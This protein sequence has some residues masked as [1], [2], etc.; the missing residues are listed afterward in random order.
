MRASQPNW[1]IVVVLLVIIVAGAGVYVFF[2]HRALTIPS[3]ST[4]GNVQRLTVQGSEILDPSGNPIILRGFNWGD[5][6]IAQQQDAADNVS[7]GANVVRI[8]FSWYYDSSGTTGCGTGQDT[9][10]PNSP[11]TGYINPSDLAILDQE[12]TWAT[13][14]H[15]WT[16]IV[17][18]GEDCDFWTN[19]KIIPEFIAMWTFVAQHYKN[20]PYIGAYELI[21]EPSPAKLPNKDPNNPEVKALYEKTIAAIR[22]IDP[23]T[24]IIVGAAQTY[25]IRDLPAI[26]MSDQSN[27]IYTADFFEPYSY[28]L[29][30]KGTSPGTASYPGYFPDTSGANKKTYTCVYP[31]QGTTVLLNK[32]FLAGLL[33]CA[34]SFR[35]TYNVPVWINQVGIRTATP[36]SSQYIQDTL[37]L[38]RSDNLGF[39]WWTYRVQYKSSGMRTGDFGSG[40]LGVYY[41]NSD[42]SWHLQS[43]LLNLLKTFITGGTTEGK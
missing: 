31:G 5:W 33:S 13:S 11:Q 40:D 23:K 15:L 12:V 2:S 16:D 19:P 37:D 43:S 38:F 20:T 22:T 30:D 34:T 1:F 36:G 21:S 6:D 41:Q 28:V 14:A 4:I 3:L 8:P 7:Q 35:S 42:N 18:R 29:E 17:A 39:A 25:D 27:L 26:Y 32:T 24:P 10:D 9:Y